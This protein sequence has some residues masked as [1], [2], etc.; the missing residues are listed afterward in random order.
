M[1]NTK[2]TIVLNGTVYDAATGK[3]L[4]T[5]SA[6]SAPADISPT[7]K[8]RSVDG[9]VQPAKRPL[10]TPAQPVVAKLKPKTATRSANQVAAQRQPERSK[11]LMRH[12]LNKPAVPKPESK[13]PAKKNSQP[14]PNSIHE[15]RQKRAAAIPKSGAI[16]R[17]GAHNATGVTKKVEH[18]P[19]QAAPAHQA[20]THKIA[21]AKPAPSHPPKVAASSQNTPRQSA[22]SF[23]DAIAHANSHEQPKASKPNLRHKTA[24]KLGTTSRVVSF[25]AATLAV[26]LLVGF[27]AYQNVPNIQ[28][29][30]AATQAGFNAKLP[31]TPSGFSM[32]GRI[33][34]AP[35][36]ITVNFRSN[37]DDRA[38][39]ITQKESDWTSTA[40]L[41]NYV[42][43]NKLPYQTY[44][45]K[46]KTI[47]IY[48]GSNA[49]WVN[50]GVWYEI[51]GSSNLNSDQLVQIANSF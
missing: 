26:L 29:R 1:A 32:S 35:G 21:H 13:T 6:A 20:G 50:G 22:V 30:L 24:R 49:T 34:S 8:P 23:T 46:G 4:H 19:V 41:D 17:F 12:A 45:D 40:L 39:Q 33:E 31:V 44:E 27:V 16:S 42:V 5:A 15:A 51:K 3:P 48:D 11:T 25:G 7:T 38:Y 28:M 43:A 47:Y 14:L 37:S 10:Q 2:T 18:L 9:F 36:Q